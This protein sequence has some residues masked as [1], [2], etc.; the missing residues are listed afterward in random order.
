M[1]I[2]QLSNFTHEELSNFTY[3]ELELDIDDLVSLIRAENRTIPV[4]TYETLLSLA[5]KLNITIP[6]G[7]SKP[8][9]DSERKRMVLYLIMCILNCFAPLFESAIEILPTNFNI[10][11]QQVNLFSDEESASCCDCIQEVLD[12]INE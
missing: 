12:K 7:I 9:T 10:T 4:D 5:G 3:A 6:E 2:M 11:I 8:H 1:T